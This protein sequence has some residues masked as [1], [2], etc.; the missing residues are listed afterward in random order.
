MKGIKND[1]PPMHNDRLITRHPR[2]FD[3]RN[4]PAE[5]YEHE[6]KVSGAQPCIVRWRNLND[7]FDDY[8]SIDVVDDIVILSVGAAGTETKVDY[9]NTTRT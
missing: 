4:L 5:K 8:Q 6:C 2:Y 9:R 7:R 1:S 3:E